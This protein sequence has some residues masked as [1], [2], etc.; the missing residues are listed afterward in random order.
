ML[1]DVGSVDVLTDDESLL[2][3]EVLDG[4]LTGDQIGVLL[5]VVAV[6]D[7]DRVGCG[8]RGGRVGR[9]P[10]VL[11]LDDVLELDEVE[12]GE[13]L[14]GVAELV[15]D[16]VLVGAGGAEE[17]GGLAVGE[18]VLV[19]G[20][21]AARWCRS[22]APGNTRGNTTGWDDGEWDDGGCPM[23]VE[24]IRVTGSR[25][26]APLVPPGTR[27]VA[28]AALVLTGP[29]APSPKSELRCTKPIC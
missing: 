18:P 10:F 28:V 11:E 25:V 13:G 6:G 9:G 14:V 7:G 26:T 8:G 20:A 5:P 29:A 1:V 16:D 27:C 15:L 3:D 12:L 17:C 24:G 22:T 23:P 19:T 21:G 2:D 4:E